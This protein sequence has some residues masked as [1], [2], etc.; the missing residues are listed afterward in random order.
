M[1]MT[2]KTLC[3]KELKLSCKKFVKKTK[4]KIEV[5]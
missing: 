5:E 3:R 4:I 2:K 1:M